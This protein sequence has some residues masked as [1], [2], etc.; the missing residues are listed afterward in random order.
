[1]YQPVGLR[2]GARLTGTVIPTTDSA[3]PHQV[4]DQGN[5]ALPLVYNNINPSYFILI[6]DTWSYDK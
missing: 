4:A 3:Y 1:M 6:I 5:A 2:A